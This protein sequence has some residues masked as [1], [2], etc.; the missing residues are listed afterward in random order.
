MKWKYLVV[1]NSSRPD[2]YDKWLTN[3]LNIC[4]KEGWELVSIDLDE[5]GKDDCIRYRAVFKRPW[6]TY[7]D[8]PD[9]DPSLV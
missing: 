4:G 2:D 6:R 1:S 5:E 3:R 7:D 8:L 9:V